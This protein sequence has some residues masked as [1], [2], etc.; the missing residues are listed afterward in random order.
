MQ[1]ARSLWPVVQ[2]KPERGVQ[3]DKTLISPFSPVNI[4]AASLVGIFANLFVISQ[5]QLEQGK[6]LQEQSKM[7]QRLDSKFPQIQTDASTFSSII[8]TVS[9]SVVATTYVTGSS[10]LAKTQP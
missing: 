7:L 3:A 2:P 1:P 10:L 4:G 5:T 8:A 9:T 6:M